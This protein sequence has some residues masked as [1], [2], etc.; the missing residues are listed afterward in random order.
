MN[1]S[2][3]RWLPV[4]DYEGLYEVSSHGNVWSAPRATTPG[5][6][7]KPQK[8]NKWGHLDVSLCAN[9]IVER[10]L[11][12]R[13]VMEAF[14]G[15]CPEGQEVRHLDGNP[16]NNRWE[17]GDEETTR[18]AG[19]N[20]IYGTRRKN[21]FDAVGHNTHFN[22]SKTHCPRGHEYTPENTYVMY[23]RDR[24]CTSRVCRTCESDRKKAKRAG[25]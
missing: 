23:R 13:L 6:I 4:P 17:P 20:L 14:V 19:G 7:L 15:P 9:G 11:L 16:G 8:V 5:G 18:R 21:V 22:A 1:E 2:N 24:D 10:H 25:A 12:H 3:E